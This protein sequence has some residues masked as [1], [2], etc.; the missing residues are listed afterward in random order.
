MLILGGN[1]EPNILV[2]KAFRKIALIAMRPFREKLPDQIRRGVD[3]GVKPLSCARRH[4]I[5]HD[6]RHGS[7][8]DVLLAI[9]L[10]GI[11]VPENRL[12]PVLV[13]ELS[14]R[15]A[16]APVVATDAA[17]TLLGEDTDGTL[18]SK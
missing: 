12:V 11:A 4:L 3:E 9:V 16:F 18:R 13:A 10:C 6:I 1:A 5:V 14:A 8:E 15:F 2:L 17:D 7:A